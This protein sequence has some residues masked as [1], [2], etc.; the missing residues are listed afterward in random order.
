ML[1]SI[2]KGR[3]SFK[4]GIVIIALTLAVW[5]VMVYV[6]MRDIVPDELTQPTQQTPPPPAPTP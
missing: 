2:R 1:E 6:N 5:A 3:V 4:T